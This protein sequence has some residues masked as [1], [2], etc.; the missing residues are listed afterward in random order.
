MS[1]RSSSPPNSVPVLDR[2]LVKGNGYAPFKWFDHGHEFHTVD[3][4]ATFG[5]RGGGH[6]MR[7]VSRVGY[8][9]RQVYTSPIVTNLEDAF[10]REA[11]PNMDK[12]FTAPMSENDKRFYGTKAISETAPTKPEASILTFAG[13][14][15]R[16]GL[17]SLALSSIGS[18][19]FKGYVHDLRKKGSQDYL[20]LSFGWAPAMKDLKE[21]MNVVLNS[22]KILSQY[23]RDSGNVV[24][25]NRVLLDSKSSGD[26]KPSWAADYWGELPTGIVVINSDDPLRDIYDPYTSKVTRTRSEKIWFSG[27]YTYY[28]PVSD[29]MLTRSENYAS[30]ARKA[31]GLELTPEV[32]WNL[33]PWTW[34]VDWF[35]NMG[36]A[37]S[38]IQ[39]F[40]DDNMV[41]KYGY[42][43]RKT[44]NQYH[45]TAGNS[46]QPKN[47]R[48]S[49]LVVATRK[50]RYRATPFGFGLN[51]DLLSLRQLS[52]LA[53][54][55][56]NRDAPK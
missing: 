39:R 8:S 33:A 3:L 43:M 49:S 56:A 26:F 48:L 50:E 27:A 51:P 53:A 7:P 2:D 25:R 32:V 6:N 46:A 37:I 18:G 23:E 42:L 14:F 31:L 15:L 4:T 34:L 11:G 21:L 12:L 17:P 19:Q 52:I 45:I 35:A 38:M 55:L 13:E 28:L 10:F 9:S 29:S 30:Y 22:H 16:D 5:S 41:I 1:Y 54:I 36:D 40:Q 44:V 24:R 47:P 20:N